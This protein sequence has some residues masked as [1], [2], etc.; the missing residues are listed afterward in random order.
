M[1]F[2]Q[3]VDAVAYMHSNDVCHRDLK[4][5]NIILEGMSRVKIIDFGF[6]TDNTTK[7]RTFCGTPTYMAPEITKRKDYLGY[8]VDNWAMGV[9]LFRL[10]TGTYPFSA[11]TDRDLFSKICQGK[12]D[13]SL[14]PDADAQAC[15]ADLLDVNPDTRVTCEEVISAY[16]AS[17]LSLLDQ[18]RQIG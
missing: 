9:I 12:V 2:S 3:L 6:S 10:I 13:L 14:I 17:K 18:I 1:I 5:E 8:Q 16:S 11:K 4:L 15:I 7:Q